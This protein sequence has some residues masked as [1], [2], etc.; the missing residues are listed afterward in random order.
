[1]KRPAAVTTKT[2]PMKNPAAATKSKSKNIGTWKNINSE[3]YHHARD[4]AYK[5][6]TDH[7]KAKAAASKACALAKVKYLAGALKAP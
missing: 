1:M 5:K 2:A 3:T 7:D 6:T 4:A